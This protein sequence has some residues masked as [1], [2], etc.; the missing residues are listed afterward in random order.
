MKLKRILTTAIVL[1]F[2][3]ASMMD[4]SASATMTAVPVLISI[5]VQEI[6]GTLVSYE[7]GLLTVTLDG[8]EVTITLDHEGEVAQVKEVTE[9]TYGAQ[10]EKLQPGTM[11]DMTVEVAR[12]GSYVL[13]GLVAIHQRFN[14]ESMP[15][16]VLISADLM[17]QQFAEGFAIVY[18]DKTLEMDVKPQVIDG[19]VMVPL[20][21]IAQALGFQVTWN[22]ETR[23]ID[24]INGARFTS[25]AIGENAYFINRM[26]PSPLSAAPVIV[27]NRTL[28]PAEFITE[29]LQQGIQI[30]DGTMKIY[31]EPFTTLSGY[32][33][34]IEELDGYTKVYVAP[35]DTD[36]VEMWEQT[37]LI[38][39][40]NTIINREAYQVGDFINGVHLPVMTMSI[41]GQTAAVIIY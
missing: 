13:T 23:R 40:E 17:N 24:L 34:V 19:K 30:E 18:E 12:D 6:R 28:V 27:D 22:A 33:S 2:T 21:A 25:V 29:I 16:P 4:V 7:E 9:S 11:I 15:V 31:D 38:V 20:R 5:Q 36:D 39:S 35:R 26:A 1:L 32:V 41:P 37:V 3:V 14:G 10:F 8:E